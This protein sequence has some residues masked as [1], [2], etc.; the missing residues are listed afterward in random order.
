MDILHSSSPVYKIKSIIFHA[1]PWIKSLILFEAYH[2]ILSKT[3]LNQDESN[4]LNYLIIQLNCIAQCLSIAT[5]LVGLLYREYKWIS[6]NVCISN[7]YASRPHC[8]RKFWSFSE[9]HHTNISENLFLLTC[10]H[11]SILTATESNY[12]LVGMV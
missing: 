2:N 8:W 1:E 7:L 4:L 11:E 10:I 6:I 12:F 3:G 9:C 5:S